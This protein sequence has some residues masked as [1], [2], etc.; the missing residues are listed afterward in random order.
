MTI[1]IKKISKSTSIVISHMTKIT[2]IIMKMSCILFIALS[3][4]FSSIIKI[5]I[6]PRRNSVADNLS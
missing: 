5:I 1:N 3:V 2:S 4:F 6:N